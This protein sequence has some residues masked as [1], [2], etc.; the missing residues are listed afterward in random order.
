MLAPLVAKGA[1]V[2]LPMQRAHPRLPW[3]LEACPASLL[4]RL[5]IYTPYKGPGSGLREARAGILETLQ[6]QERLHKPRRAMFDRIV[7][8][9]GGDALDAVI[10]GLAAART[11]A[12]GYRPVT[13]SSGDYALEAFVY[14]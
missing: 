5:G 2:A 14:C 8:D 1:A 7:D 12:G 4:K 13:D 6:R 11:V 10:A 3:L 9:P